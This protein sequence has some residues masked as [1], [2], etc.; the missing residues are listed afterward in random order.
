MIQVPGKVLHITGLGYSGTL[1][2]LQS[3]TG[4]CLQPRLETF[5]IGELRKRQRI[6]ITAYNLMRLVLL[7]WTTSITHHETAVT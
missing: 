1:M 2:K 5:T 7:I 4:P 3:G 6:W